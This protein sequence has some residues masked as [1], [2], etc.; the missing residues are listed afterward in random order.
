M[1]SEGDLQLRRSRH[2]R[3]LCGFVIEKFNLFLLGVALILSN[4]GGV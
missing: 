2:H 3:A 1:P 4:R